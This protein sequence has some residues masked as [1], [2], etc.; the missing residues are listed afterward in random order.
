MSWKLKKFKNEA[1]NQP[2]VA[3]NDMEDKVPMR[4]EI[5]EWAYENENLEG[6]SHIDMQ[7]FEENICKDG[8]KEKTCFDQT[9]NFFALEEIKDTYSPPMDIFS[10]YS[11]M[12]KISD[13][14]QNSIERPL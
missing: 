4:Q 12:L 13:G 10:S 8:N 1:Q 9:L 5:K 11:L 7:D 14:R 2:A 6:N 3:C